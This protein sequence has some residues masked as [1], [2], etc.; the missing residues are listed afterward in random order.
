MSET[1]TLT[2]RGFLV[3]GAATVGLSTTQTVAA[4]EPPANSPADHV[5]HITEVRDDLDELRKYAPK[6]YILPHELSQTRSDT[7]GQYGWIAESDEYQVTA[8]YYWTRAVTQR[9]LLSYFGWDTS[10]FDSHYTDHEPC[11]V[12]VRDDGTVDSVVCSGGHHY[13][14][15]IDGEFGNLTEERVSNRRTHVN[16]QVVRPWNHYIEAPTMVEG[17][18]VEQYADFDSWLDKRTAW[19][20]NNRYTDTSTEAI[21]DPFS[22]YDDGDQDPRTY[23]W[24]DGSWDAWIGRVFYRHRIETDDLRIDE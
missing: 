9:S 4:A 13:A 16:L 20:R 24:R 11:I 22:F 8:Y 15:E 21:E 10:L 12:Y 7:T 1:R 17:T 2:R 18:F 6:L 5:D 3:G 23:W 19:Y 14:M